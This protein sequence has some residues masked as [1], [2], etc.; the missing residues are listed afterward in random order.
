MTAG[1][2]DPSRTT[3]QVT[4]I[5]YSAQDAA[6]DQEASML[7]SP[8]VRRAYPD[9]TRARY[10]R[11]AAS[12]V[13]G[14]TLLAAVTGCG[15]ADPPQT[16]SGDP[17]PA[18]VTVSVSAAATTTS[19]PTPTPPRWAGTTQFLA[20]KAART[21]SGITYL[22]VRPAKG[23]GGAWTEVELSS[24]AVND[25]KR[26]RSGA[27]RQLVAALAERTSSERD[28]GFDVTF[29]SQGKISKATWLYVSAR[30]TAAANLKRWAGTTQFLQIQSARER[31]G[32]TYLKVRPADK[33]YLGES[34]ETVTIGGPWTEV[35]MSAPA[36][37]VPLRGVGGDA[38]QLRKQLAERTSSDREEG[39]D[40]TF[41][42][43]G[44]VSKVTWLYAM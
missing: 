8:P 26:G 35:V 39:F 44:E 28:D 17:G 2:A 18:G 37:N 20:I 19:A 43:Q 15:T 5:M 11:R 25:P 30:E 22:E 24:D 13:A 16:V 34:F 40:L 42:P 6:D 10:A 36:Q 31:A 27:A 29:N 12:L 9:P 33:E 32:I 7:L 4:E 14:C 21:T 23:K 3:A 38:G 41:L 1:T